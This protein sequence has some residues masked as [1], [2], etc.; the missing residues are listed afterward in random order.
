M[1]KK[2]IILLLIALQ[3]AFL[4]SAQAFSVRT[5]LIEI[6]IDESGFANITE[7]FNLKFQTP[8]EVTE[9]REAAQENSSSVLAWQSDYNFFYPHFGEIADK[10]IEKSSVTYEEQTQ[11]LV[12]NYV[13]ANRFSQIKTEEPRQ[14]TWRIPNRNL[15][16]FENSGLIVI[17]ENTSI[18]ITLPKNA[19]IILLEPNTSIKQENNTIFLSGISTSTFNLE[20]TIIQPL[21]TNIN[22]FER[23][24][25]ALSNTP[26]LFIGIIVTIITIIVFVKRKTIQQKIED[27]L[28]KNSE[29]KPHPQDEEVDLDL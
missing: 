22:I 25:E 18:K 20:Y 16:A 8:S 9:F 21:S 24:R 2:I 3:V 28:I 5:H 17:P 10:I 7:K 27:Y 14:T 11:T 26:I 6:Q 23:I 19:Q 15:S 4:T 1:N 12:L 29:L 13:L